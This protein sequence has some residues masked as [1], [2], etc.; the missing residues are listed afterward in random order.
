MFLVTSGVMFLCLS[1]V[2]FCKCSPLRSLQHNTNS[3]SLGLPG[4]LRVAQETQYLL[5][6]FKTLPARL[7]ERLTMKHSTNQKSSVD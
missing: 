5:L 4:P 2:G 6:L 3:S 7:R 1:L